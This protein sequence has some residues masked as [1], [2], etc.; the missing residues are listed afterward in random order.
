MTIGLA[1]IDWAILVGY[2]LAVVAIGAVVTRRAT[3]GD[4]VFLAGRSRG[5][6]AIGLSLFA[7]NISSTT[8]IGL[9]GA[10]Y[11][12]NLLCIGEKQV[13]VVAS[14]FDAMMAA[15]ERAGALRL[16]GSQVDALTKRAIVMTGEG[17]HRHWVPCKDLLG[18][19]AAVLAKAAGAAAHDDLELV[20]G[21]GFEE[22]QIT[23]EEL[24]RLCGLDFGPLRDADTF[25]V[26]PEM[27]AEHRQRTESVGGLAVDRSDH[28]KRLYSIDDIEIG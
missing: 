25:A 9:A 27:R 12:N 18:Q 1:P 22:Y 23:I 4:A 5:F 26:T 11:D 16:S 6:F 3:S 2:G 14:V 8:M 24:E 20:F 19:D 10:A 21:E 17:A 7:S 15:M 13:F 28:I